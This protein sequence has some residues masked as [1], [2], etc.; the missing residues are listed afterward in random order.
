MVKKGRLYNLIIMNSFGLGS[1]HIR[2]K[3]GIFA[4]L[5]WLSI[6]AGKTLDKLLNRS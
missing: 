6:V 5:C 2:E 4:I 3:D 1:D